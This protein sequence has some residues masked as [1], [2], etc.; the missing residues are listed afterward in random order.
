MRTTFRVNGMDCP[1]ESGPIERR[2]AILEGVEEV[3]FNLVAGTV[4]VVHRLRPETLVEAIREAGF[5]ALQL[6]GNIL[7]GVGPIVFNDRFS[8]KLR[9]GIEDGRGHGKIR[10]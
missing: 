8:G 7:R 2:L 1:E 10:D 9:G 4:M 5:E 3:A 6:G